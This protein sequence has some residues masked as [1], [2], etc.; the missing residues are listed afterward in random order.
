MEDN[1]TVIKHFTLK[2]K[3]YRYANFINNIYIIFIYLFMLLFGIV[4]LNLLPTYNTTFNMKIFMYFI[5]YTQIYK[6]ITVNY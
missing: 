3:L 6:L 2:L 1:N 4:I 5:Y